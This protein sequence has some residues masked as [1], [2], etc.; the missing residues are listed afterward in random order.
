MN[1]LLPGSLLA[2]IG[3]MRGEERGGERAVFSGYVCD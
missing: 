1:V 3:T 2:T